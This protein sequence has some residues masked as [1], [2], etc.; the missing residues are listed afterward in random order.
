M[1]E[2]KGSVTKI[3]REGEILLL[4]TPVKA[5]KSFQAVINCQNVLVYAAS[6]EKCPEISS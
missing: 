3:I 1:T 4:K 5:K 2:F 6:K